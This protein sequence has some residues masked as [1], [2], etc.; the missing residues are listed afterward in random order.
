MR[1]SGAI[2][3]KEPPTEDSPDHTKFDFMILNNNSGE[4]SVYI[5][6]LLAKEE[7]KKSELMSVVEQDFGQIEKEYKPVFKAPKLKMAELFQD[8]SGLEPAEM[9]IKARKT[10][11]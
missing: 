7:Q 5:T 2:Q 10:F 8:R 3:K 11:N 9:A 4:Q 6:P 1:E